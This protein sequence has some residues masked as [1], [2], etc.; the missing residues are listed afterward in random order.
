MAS[1]GFAL[2]ERPAH[3]KAKTVKK[4]EFNIESVMKEV[5][6]Y[7]KSRDG[8][9]SSWPLT[10][11]IFNISLVFAH[12]G[13]LIYIIVTDF[14]FPMTFF[15]TTLKDSVLQDFRCIYDYGSSFFNSSSNSFCT[16]PSLT[17][18]GNSTPPDVCT[19]ILSNND[20]QPAISSSGGPLI[21]AY[22]ITRFG[23][24]D[25]TI[26]YIDDVGRSLTKVIL[27]TI[28]SCTTIA[29]ILYSV[30][31]FRI[32]LEFRSKKSDLTNWFLSNGG[33]PLRW[34]EYAIT[35]ALMSLFIANT[36]NLFEFFGVL[37]LTM[38]TFSLMFFGAIVEKQI[39]EGKI[40]ESLLIIYIP[41]LSI[42]IA[43]WAPI[44]QSLATSVFKISCQTY[45]TD[46]FLSCSLQTCFGKNVPIPI[47]S[48]VLFVLF[49]IFPII[50]IYK[51]YVIGGWFSYIDNYVSKFLKIVTCQPFKELRLILFPIFKVLQYL[52][53]FIN[54]VIFIFVGGFIA[55][56]QLFNM[57][58]S[59][60]MPTQYLNEKRTVSKV[61]LD[62]LFLCELL[63]AIASAT[64]KIFLAVFF[65]IS[66]AD[67]D[68]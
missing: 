62:T 18:T 38:S 41:A 3:T 23:Q 14:R 17:M 34:V 66:F 50:L 56:F 32:F 49:C 29:H 54:F 44:I 53:R 2:K 47:F 20:S 48:S 60:F 11:L 68:W 64:S 37:A 10:L 22:E 15:Y 65:T 13:V 42:F 30:F 43:T 12:L 57:S 1:L 40:N 46:T 58:F 5:Q 28:E 27:I 16:D 6:I 63:Y 24:N 7:E 67:R 61:S 52:T 39:S 25:N 4:S 31:F 26:E 9:D 51:I 35:A 33:L 21:S 45:E 36:A 8:Y 19:N 59:V 55:W